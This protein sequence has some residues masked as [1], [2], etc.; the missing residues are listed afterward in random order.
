MAVTHL[1][2]SLS[3]TVGET[4]VHVHI[5]VGKK[6]KQKKSSTKE[7]EKMNNELG[8]ILIFPTKIL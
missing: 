6:K 2:I 4:K 1:S 5:I 8:D 7:E 3:T